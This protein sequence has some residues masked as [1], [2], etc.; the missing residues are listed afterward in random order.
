MSE[1]WHGHQNA[2]NGRDIGTWPLVAFSPRKTNLSRYILVYTKDDKRPEQDALL[3]QL[4]P[5][6]R[7]A[8]CLYLKHLADADKNV[9][10]QLISNCFEWTCAHYPHQLS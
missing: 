1:E 6:T 9:L 7:G 10:K 3:E 2:S 5:H 4:G 8:G